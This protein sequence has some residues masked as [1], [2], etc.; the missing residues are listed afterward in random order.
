MQHLND[1]RAKVRAEILDTRI[2]SDLFSGQLGRPAYARYLQNVWYYAQHSSIV[3]GLAGARCVP[4]HPALA[5]YLM[6]HAQE[7]LGH[8]Q[9]ALDDLAA[10][11]IT[12]DEVRES[13]PVPACAAMV[14][15]E[16]FV[17][18]HANPVGLFGWLFVLE[19]MGDDLGHE[20]A[21]RLREGLELPDG[22]K[23]LAGH[24]DADEDH[25]RDIIEKIEKDVP[26][27][28]MADVHFVADVMADLYVRIFREIG[29]GK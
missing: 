20:V 7:E 8:D 2:V 12:E 21:D 18:G 22:V 14:G 28:D 29:E 10:M 26:A 5:D 6:H 19:S 23:F 17:A 4:T 24:G 27:A 25:T 9:W 11:G 3:I 16:Y 1:L 13:R 15:M